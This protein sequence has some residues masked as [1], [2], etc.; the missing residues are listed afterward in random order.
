MSLAPDDAPPFTLPRDGPPW[1]VSDLAERFDV[2]DVHADDHADVMD[3]VAGALVNF[4]KGQNVH[5]Q[6]MRQLVAALY[7]DDKRRGVRSVIHV[8]DGSVTVD[9]EPW[10]P[11]G[12]A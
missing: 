9:R 8:R 1:A 5:N 10:T 12:D 4:D 2:A 11:E 6:A 3:T 7:A